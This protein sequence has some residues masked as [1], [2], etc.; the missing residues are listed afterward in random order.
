[1]LFQKKTALQIVL[2]AT[3]MLTSAQVA[4]AGT[5]QETEPGYDTEYDT[6]DTEYDTREA[7]TGMTMR[8]LGQWLKSRSFRDLAAGLRDGNT[9]NGPIIIIMPTFLQPETLDTQD[10]NDDTRHPMPAPMDDTE[11]ED[12]D[13]PEGITVIVVPVI[14][15]PSTG[16]Q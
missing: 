3:F 6:Y 14:I 1:M 16:G 9:S 8:Q 11:E 10:P 2:T 5:P 12:I 15:D 7:A 13:D 4:M